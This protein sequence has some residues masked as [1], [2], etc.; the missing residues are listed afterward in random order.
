[1]KKKQ[2]P[3]FLLAL[4]IISFFIAALQG[5][6]YYSSYDPFFKFLLVLQNGINAFAFKATV[7]IKDVVAFISANPSLKNRCVG[8]AYCIAVFTAPY[9]TASFVYK[10]LERM[11]RFMVGFRK[12]GKEGHILIF[13]YNAD[14][15]FMIA[16]SK[17]NL[18]KRFRIHIITAE[19]IDNEE[20][21]RL[22]KA[23][24]TVHNV[25]M[26]KMSEEDLREELDKMCASK[27]VNVILFEESSI[28]NFSLLQLFR[29]NE[30]D[31]S[32]KVRLMPG[33]KVSCRCEEEGISRLVSTYYDKIAG[34][35]AYYDLELISMPEMQIRRMYSDHPLHKIYEGTDTLL[36]DRTV[37]LLVAG[38]GEMGSQAVLQA[39]NLGVVHEQ[40]KIIIDVYDSDI[41]DKMQH[42][43]RQFG[44]GVFDF[45]D[46]SMTL[47]SDVAD[48]VLTVN[49]ISADARHRDFYAAIRERERKL[50][51]T[52]AVITFENVDLSVD[53][54][55]QVAEIFGYD[56]S[57][58]PVLIRMDAD[59]RLASYISSEH[60][61]FADVGIIDDRSCVIDLN[62][63]I[64][65]ELDKRAK[66]YNH[67]YNNIAIIS[68]DT[69][70]GAGPEGDSERE[71][72]NIRLFK[73]S[74]SKA[75]ACHD[76]VK[77]MI[78]PAL[79]SEC[80]VNLDEKLEELFGEEGKL[81]VYHA[82]AWRMNGTEDEV[83]K[84][85][86]EDSFA[87]ALASLEHRRW[88]LYMASIGWSCGERN[89]R[90]RKNPC[91]VTQ[92]K[93]METKPDMCKYDL[94]SLM[95]RYKGKKKK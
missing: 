4:A 48:G 58:A 67:I 57:G 28:R 32:Y 34:T 13:G 59:R 7:T 25:D 10:F 26:L 86:C 63:I 60:D 27:A 69:D 22:N 30:S 61:A 15:K 77:D 73:R 76:E 45:E 66:N 93:L 50:P 75:A 49:F 51:Y 88:C 17:G 12:G 24:F 40:N 18:N 55:M 9:C 82:G 56:G 42:F 72:N 21:Y 89:D 80:N 83:L 79:A 70:S 95:A 87:Y 39:M 43:I 62:M 6:I 5:W 19:A 1:M 65:R 71:W 74:S 38:L 94:L 11:L 41:R 85:M 46:S 29:L 44:V 91:L 47:K 33:A 84:K 3:S 14:V 92:E 8:Y 23:G 54:A 53:C 52:Y 16:N 20:V 68:G 64:S 35:E 31:S 36:K 2:R 37:H 78:L 81:M 90:F